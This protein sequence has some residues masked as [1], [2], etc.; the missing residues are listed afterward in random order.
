VAAPG[1]LFFWFWGAG[2]NVKS[3]FFY[4]I[5]AKNAIFL[6]KF[7]LKG[8]CPSLAPPLVMSID[9]ILNCSRG[10]VK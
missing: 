8:S 7:S 3:S 10:I 5:S 4:Q 9:M 6:K 1:F 2:I